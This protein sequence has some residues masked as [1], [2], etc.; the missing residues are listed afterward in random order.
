MQLGEDAL[1]LR[2]SDG[3]ET[4]HSFNVLRRECPCASC[5]AEREKL[6]NPGKK[7]TSLRVIQSDKPTLTQAKILEVLPVG[8]YALSFR[9]ND[10]HSTGIYSYDFL[11]TLR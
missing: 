2:W 9:W 4:R 5:R 8:R 11:L 10:G 3:S 7:L 1:E 6:A